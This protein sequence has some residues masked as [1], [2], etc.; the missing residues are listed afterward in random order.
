M[1]K[2]DSN[3]RYECDEDFSCVH[4]ELMLGSAYPLR[5]RVIR[6]TL[7]VETAL[8]LQGAHLFHLCVPQ[9]YFS[10]SNLT[11]KSKHQNNKDQKKLTD[12]GSAVDTELKT[13]IKT[14]ALIK[15]LT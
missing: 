6:L 3:K 8:T 9:F 5:S 15:H 2:P 7:T 14:F 4:V 1:L 11:L 10:E 13:K 12:P